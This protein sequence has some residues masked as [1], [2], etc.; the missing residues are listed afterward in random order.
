MGS[1]R[2]RL[3]INIY[4]IGTL[5]RLFICSTVS[6]QSESTKLTKMIWEIKR[7]QILINQTD[8]CPWLFKVSVSLNS[9]VTEHCSKLT[10]LPDPWI[11]QSQSTAGAVRRINYIVRSLYIVRRRKNKVKSCIMSNTL[12]KS[13]FHNMHLSN[14]VVWILPESIGLPDMLWKPLLNFKSFLLPKTSIQFL[15]YGFSNF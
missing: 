12:D 6:N 10:I 4:I 1:F 3:M 15:Y 8:W 2:C 7:N 9:T 13:V 14:S 5:C 11:D